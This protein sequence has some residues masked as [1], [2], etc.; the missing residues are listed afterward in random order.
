MSFKLTILGSNSALPT[1]NR[2]PTAQVLEVPGL[3]FLIDCGE[4]TQMNIRKQ[5][6]RMQKISTIF[7]KY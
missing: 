4:G 1:S 5:K 2:Y 7:I 3:C 6:I